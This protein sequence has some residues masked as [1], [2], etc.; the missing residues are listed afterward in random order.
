MLKRRV[1]TVALAKSC[2]ISS[3][4]PRHKGRSLESKDNEQYGFI[5]HH[6][7]VAFDA[8]PQNW[9]RETLAIYEYV[10]WFCL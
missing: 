4:S 5:E 1:Y 6:D 9:E 10:S 3:Q 8:A 7:F 2:I